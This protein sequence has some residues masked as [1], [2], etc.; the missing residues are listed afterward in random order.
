[1]SDKYKVELNVSERG[2]IL[3]ALS[4]AVK[5]ELGMVKTFTEVGETIARGGYPT[6]DTDKIIDNA[7]RRVEQMERLVEKL[8]KEKR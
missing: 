7:R 3:R 1:M 4:S 2:L 6:A 8:T 5:H